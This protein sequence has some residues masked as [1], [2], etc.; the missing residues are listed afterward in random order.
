[1]RLSLSIAAAVL[2][3]VA[4]TSTLAFAPS[5]S[6]ALTSRSVNVNG[7]YMADVTE[8]API[9]VTGNN[10]DVTP[11]LM[12]YVNKKFER[13]LGKLTRDPS[14]KCDVHLSVNKNPKVCFLFWLSYYVSLD[15][16]YLRAVFADM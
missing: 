15:G 5:S 6:F 11:S 14:V 3:S 8:T 9:L 2:S 16:L 4:L 1:M 13:T 7:L 12:D 10:I